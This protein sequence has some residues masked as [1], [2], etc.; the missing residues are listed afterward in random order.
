MW[1]HTSQGDAGSLVLMPGQAT[2]RRHG[3][4]QRDHSG[5]WRTPLYVPL[6]SQVQSH[7]YR[8]QTLRQQL[9]KNSVRP[10]RRRNWG[11][12]V[13]H[14]SV[15]SPTKHVYSCLKEFFLCGRLS[16][17]GDLGAA[18]LGVSLKSWGPMWVHRLPPGRS[19]SWVSAL[20]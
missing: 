1:T 17:M 14:P 6:I 11:V 15:L 12:G 13:L 7:Y 20:G 16:E 2:G 3:K 10:L 19:R 9:K 8:I 4:F 18:S 5:P